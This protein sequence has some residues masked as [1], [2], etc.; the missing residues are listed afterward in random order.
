VRAGTGD[1]FKKYWQNGAKAPDEKAWLDLFGDARS[2][3]SG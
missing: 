3:L 1:E 2:H